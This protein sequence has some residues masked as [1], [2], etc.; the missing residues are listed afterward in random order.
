MFAEQLIRDVLERSAA[1]YEAARTLAV[2][3]KTLWCKAKKY[4]IVLQI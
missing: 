2:H 4:N 1:P 3:Y